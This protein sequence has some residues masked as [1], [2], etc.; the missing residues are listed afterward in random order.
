MIS[1]QKMYYNRIKNELFF[2]T[3][4]TLTAIYHSPIKESE[5]KGI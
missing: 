4:E 3:L 1:L 5:G 2:V